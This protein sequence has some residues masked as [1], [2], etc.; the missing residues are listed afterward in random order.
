MDNIHKTEMHDLMFV[1]FLYIAIFGVNDVA[2][3][4]MDEK[5]WNLY[6]MYSTIV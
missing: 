4:K 2:A 3:F 1:Q 6:E 5:K